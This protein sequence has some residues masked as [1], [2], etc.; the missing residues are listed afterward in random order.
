MKRD[1]ELQALIKSRNKLRALVRQQRGA[2]MK[3]ACL[4]L[5]A[6]LACA[7]PSFAAVGDTVADCQSIATTARLDI[8]PSA[9]VEW[10]I[11]SIYFTHQVTLERFDGTDNAP[12]KTFVGPDWQNVAFHVTNTNR[13]RVVNDDASSR[14]ICYSGVQTK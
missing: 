1:K 11:E 2:Q 7:A 6:V 4:V 12:F 9:G 13:I 10:F 8:Q 3:V 5:F 14:I